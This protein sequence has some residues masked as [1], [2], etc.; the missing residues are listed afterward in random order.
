MLIEI[1]C[2]MWFYSASVETGVRP[3]SRL[4]SDYTPRP[5]RP[6]IAFLCANCRKLFAH[7]L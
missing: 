1:G 2:K 4:V 3:R 6:W 7:F 5:T